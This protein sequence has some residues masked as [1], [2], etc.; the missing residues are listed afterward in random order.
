MVASD[1]DTLTRQLRSLA[2]YCELRAYAMRCRAKGH[3]HYAQNAEADCEFMYQQ[4]P[5]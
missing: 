2:N 3:I 4:L 1:L 5:P